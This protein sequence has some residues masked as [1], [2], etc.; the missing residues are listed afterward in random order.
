MACRLRAIDVYRI[1]PDTVLRQ[2]GGGSGTQSADELYE[3]IRANQGDVNQIAQN[4]GIKPENIQAVKD[5][6]FYN[7]HLLD[8]YVEQGVPAEWARFDSDLDMGNSW[9][10][11][12]DGSFT[13]E[14]IQMLRHE[15]AEA[16]YMNRNGPG[17]S[18]A[19]NAAQ[20]RYPSP[21]Q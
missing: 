1:V 18:A 16:W 8:R 11:L 3:S 17:Y 9:L 15:T 4:T 6:V 10:R 7:E 20:A 2:T 5:H 12:T 19:H 14:D 13:E 21:F